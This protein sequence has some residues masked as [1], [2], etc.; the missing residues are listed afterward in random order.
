[1]ANVI[2][3]ADSEGLAHRLTFDDLRKQLGISAE[4]M[5]RYGEALEAC[6]QG[7][8]YDQ[9]TKDELWKA[10]DWWCERVQCGCRNIAVRKRCRGCNMPR[11]NCPNLPDHLEAQQDF[12]KWLAGW[13]EAGIIGFDVKF[14]EHVGGAERRAFL[15]DFR[16][17]PPNPG[18]ALVSDSRVTVQP[19]YA[20]SVVLVKA[21]VQETF[22]DWARM[23]K[24]TAFLT[25][26]L[27]SI[28]WVLFSYQSLY[29][30]FW[31]GPARAVAPEHVIGAVLPPLL[32]P[33][34]LR[35]GLGLWRHLKKGG[36]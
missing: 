18:C 10:P 7:P 35:L 12:E 30:S 20:K 3:I 4:E 14:A 16:R 32:L 24:K 31:N 15:D 1:M 22:T 29:L 23:A 27:G 13:K 8:R 5:K 17:R 28:S 33:F 9:M 34:A 21:A 2:P 6:E 36:S 19:V 26:L 25:V 11:P